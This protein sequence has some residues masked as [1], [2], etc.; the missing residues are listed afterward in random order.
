MDDDKIILLFK[1]RGRFRMKMNRIKKV[2]PFWLRA[3]ALLR[4]SGDVISV[5]MPAI[6]R[7][8]S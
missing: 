4:R 2:Q 7:R 3:Y 5:S 8:R 1:E 6:C